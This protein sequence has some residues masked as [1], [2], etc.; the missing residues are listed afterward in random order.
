MKTIVILIASICYFVSCSSEGFDKNFKNKKISGARFAPENDLYKQDIFFLDEEKQYSSTGITEY[1]FNEV[2][3]AIEEIY[4]PIFRNFGANLVLERNWRDSTVNAY[5]SQSGKSWKVAFF[6]GLARR[7]EITKE[8][9]A[10]VACHEIGHH[11]GG[12]PFYDDS[13]WASDEGNSDFY[14]TAAC[15]R[16]IFGES[17]PCS[18]MQDDYA[19]RAEMYECSF[20]Y[21]NQSQE[22]L[23]VCQRSLAGGLSLG[24]LLAKLG[25]DREPSYSTPD[26]TVVS[27]TQHSH[28]KAQC[29][30]DTYKAGAVCKSE[31]NNY[32]MPRNLQ[33]MRNNSCAERPAC[34]FKS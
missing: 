21:Q 6:G 20:N 34:W 12:Y 24:K 22:D 4:T 8:G 10:L 29:R 7:P 5:A 18:F 27:R 30:L 15:A 17:S 33:E 26:R 14:S 16:M 32:V 13:R 1:E 28:P 31:W 3:D 25:N 9:F 11:L 23:T 19:R 2:L